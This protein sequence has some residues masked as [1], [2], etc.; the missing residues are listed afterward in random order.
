LARPGADPDRERAILIGAL[1]FSNYINVAGMPSQLGALVTSY[2]LSP[3]VVVLLIMLI[4]VALGCV[5]ESLSMILL[6]VPVFYPLVQGLDFGTMIDPATI[7]KGVT[8]F[9]IVDIVRLA[10]LV[11]LPAISL[12]LPSL[13]M[14]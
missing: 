10:L 8:P 2:D 4:Y 13:M 11:L 1:I 3:L 5:L 7:F 14:R 9:W 12:W 6:T